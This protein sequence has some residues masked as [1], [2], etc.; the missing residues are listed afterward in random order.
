M[1]S[2]PFKFRKAVIMST[3]ENQ[4]KADSHMMVSY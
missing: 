3:I 1:F 2:T 4:N